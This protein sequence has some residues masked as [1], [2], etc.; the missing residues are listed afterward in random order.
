MASQRKGRLSEYLSK[1]ALGET[2]EP[3]GGGDK[4]A[5]PFF[6]VQQHD[7]SRRHWDF[8]IEVDGVLKS[9]SVPKGPSTD[10]RDKRLAV[11][12]EDHPIEYGDF[13]GVIPKGQYGA[14]AVI[15]WDTGELENLSRDEDGE[16]LPLAEALERGKAEIWLEGDK[17]R[18]GYALIHSRL[19]GDE[20][21]WLL[22]KMKDEGAD[23][24]RKPVNTEPR[25]VVSGRTTR[26]LAE[27]EG[28]GSE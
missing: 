27:E 25:S 21:N 4:G 28:A 13:E 6:V 16:P 2:P 20:R 1:R 8:R 22:I 10:P 17:L 11:Q 18:G 26:E 24:R 9:W 19:R 3:R 14:G 5:E 12:T 15:V 23:A 7:A